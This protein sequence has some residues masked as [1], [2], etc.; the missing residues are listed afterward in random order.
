MEAAGDT[1]ALCENDGGTNRN[2]LKT[3]NVVQELKVYK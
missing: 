3:A 2:V 1:A